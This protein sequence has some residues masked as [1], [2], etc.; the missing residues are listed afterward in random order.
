M[1]YLFRVATISLKL[2][3][4]LLRQLAAEARRRGLSKSALVRD[5]L[6]ASL[7]R[8]GGREKLTCL[9]LVED[10]VGGFAG[11]PDLSTNTDYLE[12]PVTAA[13]ELTRK[14]LR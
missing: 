5:T 12:E 11:L 14:R 10:I 1:Y 6:R 3:P 4:V 9:D 2:P 8:K 7:R 13:H